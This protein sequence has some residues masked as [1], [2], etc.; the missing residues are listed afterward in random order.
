[1]YIQIQM[2][3]QIKNKLTEDE[4]IYVEKSLRMYKKIK[5]QTLL[6]VKKCHAKGRANNRW[7]CECCDR[8]YATN[9]ALKKHLLSKIHQEKKN[10]INNIND[11][12]NN[13]KDTKT[14]NKKSSKRKTK[15][16]SE[17]GDQ[18]G[19]KDENSNR[20]EN[21]FEGKTPT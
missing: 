13:S 10:L 15:I 20:A 1:M 8:N 7:Y 19:E 11:G 12:G 21:S 16:K 17:T 3:Q 5:E 2:E 9:A 6:R 18:G 4:W 14:K